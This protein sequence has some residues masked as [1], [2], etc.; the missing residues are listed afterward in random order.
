MK[1]GLK[2]FVLV[3]LWLFFIAAVGFTATIDVTSGSFTLSS[4]IKPGETGETTVTIV[5]KD[6]ENPTDVI[7]NGA[8]LR[9]QER[10]SNGNPLGSWDTLITEYTVD[11]FTFNGDSENHTVMTIPAGGEASLTI[12][13]EATSHSIS[14]GPGG[15]SD[16]AGEYS[17]SFT[18]TLIEQ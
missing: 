8:S 7:F 4:V 11:G 9:R 2:V 17:G 3:S 5:I 18:I 10:D 14:W 6:I 15:P 13:V 12:T 1:K 16:D